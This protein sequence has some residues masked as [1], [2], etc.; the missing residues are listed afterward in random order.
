MKK[1]IVFLFILLMA[2]YINKISAQ[3]RQEAEISVN[4]NVLSDLS[5]LSEGDADFGNLSSTTPGDVFL[6]PQGI[7]HSYAGATAIAGKFIITGEG[8]QSVRI[9]W[10]S[11]I[12]LNGDEDDLTLTFAVSGSGTDS[13]SGS[14][15]LI[16]DE[17]FVT[18]D[19]ALGSYYIWVGGS[20]GTLTSQAAGNYS[21]TACFTVEYN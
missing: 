4:A 7:E 2:G 5:I 8:S 11:S 1:S 18:V 15:D 17:G 14:V 13:Q 20:L 10:D 3:I 6:D 16:A 21:G 9:G 12:T 19:I